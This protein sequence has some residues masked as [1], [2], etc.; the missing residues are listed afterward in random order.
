M[1]VPS[2]TGWTDGDLEDRYITSRYRVLLTKDQYDRVVAH[3]RELQSRSHF[4]NGTYAHV[5]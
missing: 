3:I 2:D 1:P 4:W 5:A